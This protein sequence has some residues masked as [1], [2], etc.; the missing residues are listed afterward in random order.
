[1]GGAMLYLVSLGSNIQ[2]EYHAGQA[3]ELLLRRYR[4][5]YLYPRVYTAAEKVESEHCFVNTLFWIRTDLSPVQ[6]KAQLCAV[7]EQLGRDRSDPKRSVRDRSCDLDIVWYAQHYNEHWRAELD[8]SYLREV[9]RPGAPCAPIELAGQLLAEGAATV[10]SQAEAGDKWVVD[11]EA[12]A[13]ENWL[14]T[15]LVGN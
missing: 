11:Q 3:L 14:E 1:M 2:P 12:N 4:S 10:Y 7:E 13:F 5:M 6:L 9:L 15:S 8:E